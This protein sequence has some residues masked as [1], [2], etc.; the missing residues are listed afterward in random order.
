MSPP[1]LV[2]PTATGLVKKIDRN[3]ADIFAVEDEIARRV[4]DNL[5][6]KIA[7]DTGSPLVEPGTQNLEAYN[8]Y[9]TGQHYL[10]RGV[11]SNRQA[12]EYF[13]KALEKDPNYA[14]AYAGITP[15]LTIIS[16]LMDCSVPLEASPKARAA[17]LKA[18]EID[19]RNPYALR[20]YQC[21]QALLMT[22][23]FYRG[24]Q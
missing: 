21:R 20:L 18:L 19:S 14:E 9:L 7:G 11:F 24:G 16:G 23:I 22:G 4:V 6:V 17:A 10:E 15:P 5:K 1:F 8:L 2:P 13:E 3:L 12:I